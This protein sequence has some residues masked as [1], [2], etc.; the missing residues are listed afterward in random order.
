MRTLLPSSS[1]KETSDSAALSNINRGERE[2][3]D[4]VSVK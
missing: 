1:P 3:M 4:N 2:F